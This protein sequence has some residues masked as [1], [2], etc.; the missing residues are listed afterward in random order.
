MFLIEKEKVVMLVLT[1]VDSQ[2]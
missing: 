2:A 1:S